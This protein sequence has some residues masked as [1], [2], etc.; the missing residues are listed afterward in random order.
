[1]TAWAPRPGRTSS[2]RRPGARGR[3][4]ADGVPAD[5]RPR[6]AASRWLRGPDPRPEPARAT[7]GP[8]GCSPRRA[9]PAAWP[10]STG[11]AAARPSAPPRTAQV[12]PPH[13]ACSSTPS[14]RRSATACPDHLLPDWVAAHRRPARR[15]RGDRARPL[16]RARRPAARGRDPARAR[17]GDRARRRRRQRRRCRAAAGAAPDVVKLD[18]A[19]LAPRLSRGQRAALRAV[20]AY[21][22]TTGAAVVAEGIETEAHLAR[23][24]VAR[25][26]LGAGL[27]ARPARR[28]AAAPSRRRR[29]ARKP[30]RVRPA[31]GVDAR[32]RADPYRVLAAALDRAG[33][34]GPPLTTGPCST[35]VRASCEGALALSGGSLALVVL[36]SSDR[37]AGRPAAP[38]RAAARRVRARGPA[39]RGRGVLLPG[40]AHD[41][42]RRGRPAAAGRR[43]RPALAGAG[44]GAARAAGARTAA[45]PA[46][47]PTTP[48]RSARR[49]GCC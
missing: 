45:G 33:A 44:A 40:G 42:A 4:P 29:R 18:M 2:G 1:M 3:R 34:A 26:R 15:R 16:R 28:P 43:C 39:H 25:R 27:A 24:P 35:E 19:L 14:R 22:A 38:A 36:G 49:R 13:A 5:P 12:G 48:P 46:G 6:H 32:V 23:A 20:E 7:S 17:L 47:A 41:R 31:P 30:P 37:A 21:V 9:R 11:R 10:S 8:T